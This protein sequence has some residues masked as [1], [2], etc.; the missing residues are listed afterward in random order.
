MDALRARLAT[1]VPAVR[2]PCD[3]ITLHTLDRIVKG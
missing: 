1:D 3:C 2:Q